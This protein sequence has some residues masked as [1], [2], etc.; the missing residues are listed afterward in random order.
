MAM[1]SGLGM[2]LPACA[3]FLQGSE[4]TLHNWISGR[5]VIPFAAYKLLRLLNRMELPAGKLISPEGR[6][7]EGRSTAWWSLLVRRTPMFDLRFK[8]PPSRVRQ[9]VC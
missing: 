3:K 1:Y 5:H 4:R 6:V 9:E 7:F 8:W 2:D